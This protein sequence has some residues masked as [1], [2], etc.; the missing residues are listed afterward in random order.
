MQVEQQRLRTLIGPAY[1]INAG[2]R[3]M[4]GRILQTAG[5]GRYAGEPCLVKRLIVAGIISRGC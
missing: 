5:A 1:G 2:A 3:F 4:P